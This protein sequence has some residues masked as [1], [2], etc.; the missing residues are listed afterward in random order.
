MS[1]LVTSSTLTNSLPDKKINYIPGK[2]DT[3]VI[4]ALYKYDINSFKQQLHSQI[5]Y[6]NGRHH[7]QGH[8]SY[9]F[10]PRFILCNLPHSLP[11]TLTTQFSY[12]YFQTFLIGVK[13][14]VVTKNLFALVDIAPDVV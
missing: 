9:L 2:Y 14:K 13:I 4:Y 3:R 5:Q 12:L 11:S 1:S 7:H 8:K 6:Y 10:S